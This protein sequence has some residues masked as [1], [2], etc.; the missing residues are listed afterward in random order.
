LIPWSPSI[1]WIID[2]P[3]VFLVDNKIKNLCF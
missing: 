3:T 2:P 1:F